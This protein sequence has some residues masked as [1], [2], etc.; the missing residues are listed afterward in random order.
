MPK[1]KQSKKIPVPRR[2]ACDAC[3]AAKVRCDH[4]TPF[5]TRCGARG[6]QCVYPNGQ[7]TQK[8]ATVFDSAADAY[9]SVNFDALS[10]TETPT[11]RA[12][13]SY[14]G[15][16]DIGNVAYTTPETSIAA[17]PSVP[18]IL[19]STW[20]NDAST[21]ER[22]K[23]HTTNLFD[24]GTAELICSIDATAIQNRWLRAFI[25]EPGQQMKS[26]PP[27]I[28]AYIGR[29]LKSYTSAIIHG[30]NLPP[31]VHEQQMNPTSRS[32]PLTNCFSLLALCK[33][34]MPRSEGM[35]QGLIEQK[36]AKIF[37]RRSS[38]DGATLLS[39]FQTH[40]IYVMTLYFNLGQQG[41]PSLRQHMVNL[42]QL[43]CETSM[44]GVVCT[45]EW[46]HSRP[47]W[48]SWIQAETKRRTLYIMYLFDNLLCVRDGL[49]IFI[50]TELKG[51]PAPASKRLWRASTEG[52]WKAAYNAYLS[53]WDRAGLHIDELW[54]M[55]F[56]FSEDAILERRRKV[57][58]W[59]ESVDEYGT[60]LYAVTICTHGG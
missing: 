20:P 6:L 15:D 19:Q 23:D 8:A 22:N 58:K 45:A 25:P 59:L 1:V 56:G 17:S 44:Q 5:C 50:S 9:S 28:E 34:R 27:G 37:D 30:S 39:T 41:S 32:T 46:D 13:R 57:G 36:M 24:Q 33:S 47:R 18:G 60:M 14:E 31:F 7:H 16:L 11:S 35:A 38:Y 10:P 40:L 54:P 2:K 52:E 51:L 29:I 26:N 3:S 43:A 48:N 12:G 49:P 55:P 42:Q 53:E 4:Q 21:A